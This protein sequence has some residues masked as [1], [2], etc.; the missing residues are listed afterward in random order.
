MALRSMSPRI[1]GAL[2][3]FATLSACGSNPPAL[4]SPSQPTSG[5][6]VQQCASPIALAAATP[7]AATN[8]VPFSYLGLGCGVGAFGFNPLGAGILGGPLDLLAPSLVPLKL[9]A[10]GSALPFDAGIGGF[11]IGGIGAYGLGNPWIGAQ[12][13]YGSS[14]GVIGS[15]Q[16][17]VG[18]NRFGFGPGSGVIGQGTVSQPIPRA[19]PVQPSQPLPQ[20]NVVQS[21]N[22][23]EQPQASQPALAQGQGMV[24][25]QTMSQGQALGNQPSISQSSNQ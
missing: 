25:Q 6:A 21:S 14:Y 19:M 10:I 17:F 16:P 5:F 1:T 13:F 20:G 4:S 3:G 7:V 18:L 9:G 22:N 24:N 23:L 2:I 8:L 12:S 15:A 11:G